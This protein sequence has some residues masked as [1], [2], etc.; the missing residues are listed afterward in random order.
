LC[1]FL[2]ACLPECLSVS[3]SVCLSVCPPACPPARLPACLPAKFSALLI[4]NVISAF[5]K[6]ADLLPIL[7]VTAL[8]SSGLLPLEAPIIIVEKRKR[9]LSF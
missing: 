3:L 4:A 2:S 6:L 1:V 7:D 8:I 5:V 9:F